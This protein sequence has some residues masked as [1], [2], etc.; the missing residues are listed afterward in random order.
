MANNQYG[1]SFNGRRINHPGAYDHI[2]ASAMTV[3][4]AGST[5]VPIVVGTAD[6][7]AEGVVQWFTSAEQ[8]RKE[9][10]GGDL[11]TAIELM[12][13]PTPEGG[14][15][16]SIVGAL[17]VN[18]NTNATR[19][20]GG[21]EV[22]ALEYGNGGNRIQVKTENG[23]LA[24]SKKI[25]ISRW[26]TEQ[27]EIYNNLGPVI[28]IQY[29]GDEEYA[30]ISVS[31]NEDGVPVSIETKVGADE[32]SAVSDILVDLTSGEYPTIASI[33]SH[34][35]NVSGYVADY[36]N[37]ANSEMSSSLL[38]KTESPV[39]IK[40][41]GYL[42][43]VTGDIEYQI[44]GSSELVSIKATAPVSNFPS[45]YLTGG[46]TGVAPV[47]WA[48]YFDELKKHFSDVLVVLNSSP[49]IHAEALQHVGDMELRQQ[50][51]VLFTGGGT[52]ETIQ[53]VKQRAARLN[54]SRAVLAYPGIY[55]KSV[56]NGRALPAYFTGALIAG[57]VCGVDAS[58]PIT[59]DYFNLI[60][61]EN[62]LLAGDPEVDDLISAG[63]AT[64]EMVQNGSVRLVQ[65]IT[66][67]ISANNTLY[68]EISVRRGADKLS[69]NVRKALE[70][71]FVGKKGLSTTASSVATVVTDVLDQAIRDEQITA[72]R[73]I[74]VRFVGTAIYVD[75]EVAP[76]Q[77][78]NFILVTS[79][80]VPET[81]TSTN[82]NTDATQ[83]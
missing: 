79:H 57:R 20:A 73:N 24:G 76:V 26:D 52:G 51:Q 47:S 23:T 58:E 48:K 37:Y 65:G 49:S 82:V 68:R 43:S 39:L 81:V 71:T 5:N 53:A 59:F 1:I 56:G 25:T 50:K 54:N 44:N 6:A 4:T 19:T 2:D 72:Y 28:S 40:Q 69:E 35:N 16:A 42:S 22:S 33:V 31:S 27:V 63:V 12:F 45:A 34:F 64:L 70:D 29:T 74:I 36:I 3:V 11:V 77:P 41:G 7:G 38:D 13:S 14:G 62:K 30:S 21:L 75:Y 61:L 67:Y 78:I 66:T 80:F 9:L 55:H 17:V 15:G 8:A 60:G 46:G 32:A 83:E 10:R 18:K